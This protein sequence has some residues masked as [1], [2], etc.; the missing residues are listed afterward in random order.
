VQVVA[1]DGATEGPSSAKSQTEDKQ[2]Q[3]ID[4]QRDPKR[5]TKQQVYQKRAS[6]I[7]VFFRSKRVGRSEKSKERSIEWKKQESQE[8]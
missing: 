2:P 1:T 8:S 6:P 5:I 3:V 7:I 4:Q